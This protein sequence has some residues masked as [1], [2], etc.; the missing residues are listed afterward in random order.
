MGAT[1]HRKDAE[2]GQALPAPAVNPAQL[3]A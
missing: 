3:E 1:T 2:H